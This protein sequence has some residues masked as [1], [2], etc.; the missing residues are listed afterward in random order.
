MF[1]QAKNVILTSY[2]DFYD[3]A[4]KEEDFNQLLGESLSSLVHYGKFEE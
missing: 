3:E 4:T 2:D 1:P